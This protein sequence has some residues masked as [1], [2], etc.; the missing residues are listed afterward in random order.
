[1]D[2][3]SKLQVVYFLL[4]AIIAVPIFRRIGLGAILGYLV[5]GAAIGPC[6]FKLI[7]DPQSAMH[8][9]EFGVV[10]LLFVIGLEIDPQRLWNARIK[11]LLLGGGQML[12]SGML[13][14]G[15]LLWGEFT[16]QPAVLLG[17]T[18]ALSSTAFAVPLME[19][20]NYMASPMGRDAFAILLLQ[21]LAVIPLLLLLGAWAKAAPGQA[22][23]LSFWWGLMAI[24]GV[25]VVGRFLLSP[26]LSMVARYGSREIMTALDL[27]LVLGTALIMEAVGLSMGMGAFIA[28][29]LLTSSSFKHQLAADIEP[30]KGL[31]L[32]LFFISVGMTLD[33]HLLIQYP[34]MIF[35]FAAALML[36][37]AMV[38][39][40]LM[41][42]CGYGFF[43]GF[44]LG[45]IMAQGG[46]FAFVILEKARL[47]NFIPDAYSS[48][49]VLVVGV[50]MALTAPM[51]ILCQ[52][53]KPKRVDKEAEAD[54]IENHGP[55]VLIIGFGRFGQIVGRLLKASGIAFTAL[56]KDSM[57]VKFMQEFG[58][59]SYFGDATRLDLLEA[60]GIAEA[61]VVVVA[62]DSVDDSM[63]IVRLIQ[64]HFPHVQCIARARNRL[65]VYQLHEQGIQ[66]VIR[67]TFESSLV[68]AEKTLISLGLT[69][70]QAI[71]KV[72]IYR[73]WD[74]AALVQAAPL[75]QDEVKLREFAKQ[76]V[77]ELRVLMN[78]AD[79]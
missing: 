33:L 25:I 18:L 37:K 42:F 71:E 48:Y 79:L 36:L 65:H 8:L 39:A 22:A 26:L 24:A 74:E 20:K 28:G 11:V 59:K 35:G 32:G 43:D 60:A 63:V 75:F 16:W 52:A 38:I 76:S 57:Q 23:S 10:M 44:T 3:H 7:P 56:E 58:A 12:I 15:V 64:S 4:A 27:L 50:S 67:E 49:L 29:L 34:W 70:S 2:H 68:A 17:L 1:M 14:A 9:A 30:F 45:M 54:V 21:D 47:I 62:V 41:R 72:A 19:E 61:K 46:E 5:A 40:L 73:D 51:V 6:A 77:E 13:I 53:F 78:R 55:E 31:L 66:D 69:E